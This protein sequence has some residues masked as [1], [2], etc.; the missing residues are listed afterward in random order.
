VRLVEDVDAAPAAHGRQADVLA[1]L[2]DVV[3]GV[4]RGGVHLDDVEGGAAH[5]GPAAKLVRVEVRPRPARRVER[6]GQ[7]LR[8]ARLARAPG[9]HEEVGVVHLVEPD[10]VAERPDDVLL[11]HHVAERARPV[12]TVQRQHARHP[13]G[14]SGALSDRAAH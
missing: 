11:A 5:D 4:V 6:A 10:R 12:A 9:A 2:A 13:S 14:G 3:D 8:H 7:E 1:Q